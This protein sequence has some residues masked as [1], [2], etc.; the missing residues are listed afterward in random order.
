MES[1]VEDTNIKVVVRCRPFSTKEKVNCETNCVHINGDQIKLVNP[2]NSLDEQQFGFDVVFD[3]SS[4][5][6]QV[7]SLL[8]DPILNK[9]FS[10]FNGTIFA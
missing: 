6:V 8:G 7:W 10:G 3:Q 1:N 9:A 5:Q 4:E 2:N